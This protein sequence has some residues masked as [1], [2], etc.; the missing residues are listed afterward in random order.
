MHRNRNV[1][2][3]RKKKAE[4]S[5]SNVN[6]DVCTR[7]VTSKEAQYDKAMFGALT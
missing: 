3:L 2:R 1:R 6:V 7:I 4:W 5:W